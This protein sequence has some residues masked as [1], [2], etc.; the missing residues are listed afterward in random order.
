[1]FYYIL[2]FTDP[3]GGRDESLLLFA[4]QFGS[5]GKSNGA[6]FLKGQIPRNVLWPIPKGGWWPYILLKLCC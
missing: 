1:M 5:K 6:R 2:Y 3:L 4:L